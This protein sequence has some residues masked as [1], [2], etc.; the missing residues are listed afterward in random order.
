[1]IVSK[2]TNEFYPDLVAA[3]GL[4]DALQNALREICSPLTVSELEKSIRFVVY[5]RVESGSRF[6]QVY[7][8]AQERLFLFDFWA[9]GVM[10][11][12]GQ[13]P[14]LTAMARAID[15]W[16][17]SDCSTTDLVAGFPFVA[18]EDKAAAYERGEEVEERWRSYMASIGFPELVAFVAAASQRPKLRQLFP[19]TSL[20][21]FCFSRCTGYPFTRD[22]PYVRPLQQ[23]QY[24]V[25][26]RKGNVL[27]RGNAEEAAD[28]VVANLPPGCAL[29]VP[30]TA[31]DLEK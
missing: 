19:Y 9:R 14:H 5:A 18:V 23:G 12:Q 25:V 6:S 11:A 21:M 20:N 31:D 15:K 3:G 16:V 26:S 2:N 1:M 8:A 29:A 24:E 22:T 13:T 17:Q 4:A 27:G 30:G 28:L 10:L 7:I